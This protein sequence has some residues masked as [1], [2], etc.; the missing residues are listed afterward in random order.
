MND[1]SNYLTVRCYGFKPRPKYLSSLL[2]RWWWPTSDESDDNITKNILEKQRSITFFTP[3]HRLQR[4]GH[5]IDASY[6]VL[7]EPLLCCHSSSFQRAV[8]FYVD[9]GRSE[10]LG[11]GRA[12]QSFTDQPPKFSYRGCHVSSLTMSR[13]RIIAWVPR[14]VVFT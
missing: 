1:V 8:S 2:N 9:R 7:L 14:D 5:V 6:S 12:K 4:H 10:P 11:R 3:S 13:K